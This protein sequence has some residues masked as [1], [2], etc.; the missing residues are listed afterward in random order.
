MSRA[1]AFVLLG[2]VKSNT[3]TCLRSR[4]AETL[5]K[6]LQF[7]RK[8]L[9]YLL[10][11]N[12]FHINLRVT[13]VFGRH[14]L[15]INKERLLILIWKIYAQS[16]SRESVYQRAFCVLNTSRFLRHSRHSRVTRYSRV[17]RYL[18]IFTDRKRAGTGVASINITLYQ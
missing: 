4:N 13:I 5:F 2:S 7:F 14:V 6:R 1:S 10:Q 17:A 16:S 15:Q 3:G 11:I 9:N 12:F 18:S 8:G